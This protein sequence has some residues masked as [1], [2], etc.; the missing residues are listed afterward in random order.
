MGQNVEIRDMVE[1]GDILLLDTDR[2]FTGQD[3]HAITPGAPADGVPGVLAS[4]IFDLGVG[5]DYIY[6]LQN[7]VTLRRSG[8]WDDPSL[9]E[10]VADTTRY[11]LRYYPGAEGESDDEGVEASSE[12]E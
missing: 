11:F 7:Q 10:Q 6:V 3:G 9:R 1:M 12:E 8:G 5:V 4:R 2:S